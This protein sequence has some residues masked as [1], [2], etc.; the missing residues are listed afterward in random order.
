MTVPDTLVPARAARLPEKSMAR[1]ELANPATI[2]ADGDG[3]ET[4]A[5]LMA[6]LGRLWE[7]DRFPDEAS[8]RPLFGPRLTDVAAN[9]LAHAWCGAYAAAEGKARRAML[10]L[11]AAASAA[12][13][14]PDEAN[15]RLFRRFNN[16]PD[17]LRFLVALRADMLRW[18][19]QVA[20]LQP[21]D[22]ALEGLLS[23]WFDVGLLDLRRLTWD[24]PASLL[25][26]LIVYEAVHEIQSWDDLKH[27]VAQDRRC[28]AFFH[29][30]MPDIPLIF[31]EVAFAPQMAD[32]V[33]ALLDP[34]L[35]PQNLDKARWA[36]FYSISNTQPGLRGIS[37]GNFLLK[38]VIDQLLEE[39][40]K[41]KSFAT[42]SPIPG[43][44]DWLGRL[45]SDEVEAIVRERT[46]ERSR[47]GVPD[48]QRWLARLRRAAAGAAQNEVVQRAGMRLAA[49][50][51]QIMKSGAPLDPVARFHL[52]NG[53]R[54]E[55]INW[56]ADRSAKGLA[57][58]AGLMV[59]Y[60]YELDALDDNLGRLNAG[61][62]AVSRAIARMG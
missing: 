26:K 39:L 36:I 55:R 43:L 49:A 1:R 5:G 54:I 40:P 9:R 6:R 16:Q 47:R 50:Y 15:G 20:G 25:E 57:Q 24:S 53:A 31:V 33:Q 28:Y 2:D 14:S 12:Q 59:N 52:G 61:K 18:R 23:A 8:L 19:K 34:H 56:A 58:S 30:Q 13:E 42:L 22:R 37:F 21:L 51:L 11:L 35:P 32:N 7:R 46:R 62:P 4:E 38:R 44:A 27:R 17:G 41:L 3:P 48:G 10:G 29:P 60:L 45:S